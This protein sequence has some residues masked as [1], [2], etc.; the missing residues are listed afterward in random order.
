[1]E[2]AVEVDEQV[3]IFLHL[4]FSRDSVGKTSDQQQK[5]SSTIFLLYLY[6]LKRLLQSLLHNPIFPCHIY[7]MTRECRHRE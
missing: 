5:N 6:G 7:R 3:D 4:A 1:M 2:E